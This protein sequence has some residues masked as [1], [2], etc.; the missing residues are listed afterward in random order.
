MKNPS[1][2]SPLW[3]LAWKRQ[4]SGDNLGHSM[5]LVTWLLNYSLLKTKILYK[6]ATILKLKTK[7]LDAGTMPPHEG[8]R[9]KCQ[10]S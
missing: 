1:K 2:Y 5:E 7:F 10:I 3:S 4:P 6:K 8:K 9:G